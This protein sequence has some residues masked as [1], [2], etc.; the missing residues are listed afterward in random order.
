MAYPKKDDAD[1]SVRVNI[2][3]PPPLYERLLKFCQIEERHISWV[4]HK[5][6]DEWLK[7]KGY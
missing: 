3:V 2:T 6:V 1:K 4:V 5:A 7:S